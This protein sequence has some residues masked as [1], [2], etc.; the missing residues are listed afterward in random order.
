MH[1]MYTHYIH[2]VYMVYTHT[3]RYIWYIHTERG[4][5]MVYAYYV[6]TLHTCG[7]YGLYTHREIKDIEEACKAMTEEQINNL[8][9]IKS[10][11][12]K[13]HR[14]GVHSG[15]RGVCILCVYIQYVYC[16]HTIYTVYIICVY[17]Q[18]VYCVHTIYTHI[19]TDKRHRSG[20]QNGNRRI[21]K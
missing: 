19:R 10:F 18:Y 2:T 13:R 20:A 5:N 16:I 9:Q 6:H 4:M 7:I 11:T 3:E 1:T 14:R 12:D 15:D 21:D 17:I 8:L